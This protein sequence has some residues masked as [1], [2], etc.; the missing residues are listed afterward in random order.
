MGHGAD[1]GGLLVG[2]PPAYPWGRQPRHA[3]P[4][5]PCRPRDRET[6]VC[7]ESTG[8]CGDGPSILLNPELKVSVGSL[9]TWP[10]HGVTQSEPRGPG[11]CPGDRGQSACQTRSEEAQLSDPCHGVVWPQLCPSSV[12][13]SSTEMVDQTQRASGHRPQHAASNSEE[14]RSPASGTC[15]EPPG[16]GASQGADAAARPSQKSVQAGPPHGQLSKDPRHVLRLRP[17]WGIPE[18]GEE[19]DPQREAP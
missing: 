18:T 11:T 10:H 16:L 12:H 6:W 15:W 14:T 19:C 17:F 1:S 5:P 4:H 13:T 2:S 3:G 8:T 9:V 7:P